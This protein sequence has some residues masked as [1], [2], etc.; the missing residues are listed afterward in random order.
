M[1]TSLTTE[2]FKLI[3]FGNR[4]LM[5]RRMNSHS[6]FPYPGLKPAVAGDDIEKNTAEIANKENALK[7]TIVR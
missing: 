4:E 1:T 3:P 5:L 6:V 7:V 2:R